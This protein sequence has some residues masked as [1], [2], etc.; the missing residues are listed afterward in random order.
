MNT[1]NF[2]GTQ[3]YIIALLHSHFYSWPLF[4]INTNLILLNFGSLVAQRLLD[5]P[6]TKKNSS[7]GMRLQY[8]SHVTSHSPTVNALIITDQRGVALVS[9]VSIH[10]S[11]NEINTSEQNGFHAPSIGNY[12]STHNRLTHE[13]ATFHLGNTVCS[14]S[15]L[16]CLE[17]FQ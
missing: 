14:C 8:C 16:M 13:C 15:V 3:V 1:A 6:H 17:N 9:L 2:T 5:H 10:P 11:R 7:F 4:Q 12:L